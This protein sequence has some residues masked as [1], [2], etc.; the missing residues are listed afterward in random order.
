MAWLTGW[1]HRKTVTVTGQAG[2]GTNYQVDF[3]IGGA[4]G[5][6]FH[7]E[8]HCTSFPNDIEVTDN[9]QT[10]T[11]DYWVEDLT[12][13]PITMWVEVA[14]DLGSNVDICFYYDKSGASST[15]NGGNT[16]LFF[17]DFEAGS[18]NLTEVDPN[19]HIVQDRTTDHRLEYN[20]LA[21]DE[22]AYV[23]KS[24]DSISDFALEATVH[25]TSQTSTH[26]HMELG[27]ADS[28]GAAAQVNNGLYFLL[29]ALTEGK[30]SHVTSGSPDVSSTIT[31]SADTT[32]Y[33]ILTRAGTSCTLNIYT[34]EARTTHIS[35]SPVSYTDTD[36]VAFTYVY[37]VSSW[38]ITWA[39]AVTGW[40]DGIRVRK[41][42]S[43][44]PAYSSAGAEEN[45][46]TGFVPY[47]HFS[48]M[49]GGIGEA[50]TGGI[51]R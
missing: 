5:G 29:R 18:S 39:D 50:M 14:D 9:D 10:T 27:F 24:I 6:D 47:P 40:N 16:F 31:L 36:P 51:A 8:N 37:P 48:G 38:H 13:D 41:Y 44:E 23:Y 11:L 35:G 30:I 34:D 45:E 19:S 12:V 33:I 32:Y 25:A 15:S 17:D 46:P 3:S 21:R 22:D 26:S 28:V 4:S 2:A 43:T 49:D 7:L 42:A 1:S 20:G